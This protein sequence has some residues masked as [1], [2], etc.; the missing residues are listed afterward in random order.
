MCSDFPQTARKVSKYKMMS[1]CCC[2]ECVHETDAA[3]IE[4]CGRII[5]PVL[6]SEDSMINLNVHVII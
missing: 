6:N 4:N 5:L 3:V 2:F 1:G